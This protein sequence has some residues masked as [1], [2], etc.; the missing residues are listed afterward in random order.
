MRCSLLSWALGGLL[1]ASFLALTPCAARQADDKTVTGDD[2]LVRKVRQAIDEGVAFLRTQQR[3]A[4]GSWE[5]GQG[6]LSGTGGWTA[7][8]LLTLLN[9]GVKVEDDAVQKGL[10][11]LRTIPP[12][13]TYVVGLQTMVFCLAKQAEDRPRIQRNVRWLLESRL[14][15]GWTY[16]KE[17]GLKGSADNSNTQYAML[18]LHEA[19]QAGIGVDV[20]ALREL[21]TL[22]LKTQHDGGWAY[23]PASRAATM[24][25]TTAGLCDLIISGTDLAMTTGT[26]R[27]DGSAENCGVYRDNA[28]VA[29]ALT[30]IGERF[31]AR[32]TD[33]N[34]LER[35]GSPF[36][37]LYG[38]ERAGR[39]T[40]QRF[41]GGHDWY[42]VGCRYLVGAQKADG[43]WSGFSGRGT[44]DP[45]PV[46][47]TSF[48]LLFLS[49]GRTPVLISK[50]AYGNAD[51]MGWN[52][53]R[54]DVRHLVEFASKEL[55]K[56]E[57]LAW[58]A[59]DVRRFEA[60]TEASRRQLAAQLLQSPLV[61]VNGHDLAPRDKEAEVLKEYVAGGG[62]I[63]A[64]NC[65]GKAR[66]P[67]FDRD[68][69]RLMKEIFPDNEL[70]PLEPEHPIWLAS[71][72]FAVSPRDF[73][74]EGIKMGCKTVVV[75]SPVPLAGYWEQNTVADRGRG[76]KAFE[77]GANII[78]Y[79][80]GLEPPR[81]RL[82]R[83]EIT[84]D[85]AREPVRRGFLQVGQLRHEGDW[86]PAPRAMRNLMAE[87]RKAGLDVLLKTQPVYP[88]DEAVL[89]YRFLYMHGRNTF[90]IK[91]D[92]LKHLRFNLTHGGL[93][94][95]DACCGSKTYDQAF[96]AF[97]AELFAADKLK[98]EPIPTDDELYS[99]D[100]NGEEIRTVRR[101]SLAAS[102]RKVDPEYRNYPPALE[103][104]K[105]RGRWV[106]I[107]SKYDLGC[108]LEKH[109]SP[110]C[111]G[112][113]PA[114][115]LRLARAAVLYALRR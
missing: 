1:L 107:Y 112:H 8:V 95:A 5:T 44:F 10:A 4:D 35:F 36:Y 9:A 28:A 7:L 6:G 53:K 64:E 99:R 114:S 51:Y 46:I 81:P 104:V 38:I 100:L 91:K 84:A 49:K 48:S 115:A 83:V 68:F 72:K 65:C 90:T 59:F 29:T 33:D 47:A 13:R 2:D 17:G 31:P 75:Y 57:P 61:F 110:D 43:S 96:R 25:M 108:A 78:A 50:L 76:R 97:I 69:R 20:K 15:D 113:D 16:T 82:S 66:H 52:N 92:D 23:K 85:P 67:D 105:Y 27:D 45:W 12:S 103:G 21:Q 102:G 42:E 106:V 77:L 101:R 3:R 62:F 63:L 30:W 71:G 109:S 79:A 98:L 56:G 73:P 89:D 88:A 34:I 94:L 111:L 22:Y 37:C 80:T 18:G 40:G 87:A 86:Q 74:L 55:F 70:Q 41:F 32:L 19:A 14:P 39:L 93:L 11:Y 26:L 54:H 24:T 58:Q 60:N